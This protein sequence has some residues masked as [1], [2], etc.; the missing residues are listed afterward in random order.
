MMNFFVLIFIASSKSSVQQ[1]FQWDAKGFKT[2]EIRLE[3]GGFKLTGRVVSAQSEGK[4]AGFLGG[5]LGR[6]KTK[7]EFLTISEGEKEIPLPRSA[8]GDW[9]DIGLIRMVLK[10][11]RLSEIFAEGGDAGESYEVKLLFKSGKLRE[12]IVNEAEDPKAVFE[13]TVY[14]QD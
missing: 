14:A 6:L 11:H 5:V 1:E 13:R 12:R 9:S 4:W 10:N 8:Y 3:N 2:Q 7:L